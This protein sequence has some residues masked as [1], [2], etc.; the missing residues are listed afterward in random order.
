M[1]LVRR[2]GVP[3]GRIILAS[4][5]VFTAASEIIKMT[6]PN[7]LRTQD[8][9]ESLGYMNQ[10]TSEVMLLL[11]EETDWTPL[12][13][14]NLDREFSKVKSR[15]QKV[16]A[17]LEVLRAAI[18]DYASVKP[19]NN[20]IDE[21]IRASNLMTTAAVRTYSLQTMRLMAVKRAKIGPD[22]KLK[23][24]L[25][26]NRVKYEAST[27]DLATALVSARNAQR[28]ITDWVASRIPG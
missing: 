14:A 22:G 10:Q 17:A 7:P 1:R 23:F 15:G 18:E 11:S 12:P 19:G 4:L 20:S 9:V 25:E 27:S 28:I 21:V 8:I 5:L 26:E 24:D 16:A 2:P 6:R 3:I 13:G